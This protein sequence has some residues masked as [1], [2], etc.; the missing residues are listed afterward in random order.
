MLKVVLFLLIELS[1]IAQITSQNIFQKTFGSINGNQSNSI[2]L[3]K[4]S[5]YA[6]GGWYDVE[7]P[8]SAE[9][10]LIKLNSDGDTTWAYTYGEKLDTNAKYITEL[11]SQTFKRVWG[12]GFGS[13]GSGQNETWRILSWYCTSTL[14]TVRTTSWNSTLGT[15]LITSCT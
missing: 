6:I 15:C 3:T 7:G 1:L 2:I 5:G 4:D 11:H 8:L 10:Y 14:G 13:P 12:L 9:L